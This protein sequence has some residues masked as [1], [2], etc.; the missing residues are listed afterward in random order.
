MRPDRFLFAAALLASSAAF[1]GTVDVRFID[2]A[3]FSDLATNPA[4]EAENLSMLSRHL[5]NLGAQLPANQVLHI[6]VLDVD[7]AGEW[8]VTPRGRIR[9]T[10]NRHDA[11]KF[12]L[13]YSLES[14]GQMLRTGEDRITDLDY[15]NR[16]ST[17]S[18]SS[19][20]LY[21][22]KRLLS[23]WFGRNFGSQTQALAR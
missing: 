16:F 1:A 11:P 6:D 4:D 12:L 9:V 8:R 23:E 10:G 2:P 5:Q 18:S 19:T 17:L 21:Y 14:G 20:P 22:E 13:R 7:L 3:R 15:A